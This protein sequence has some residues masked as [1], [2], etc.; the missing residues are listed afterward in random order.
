MDKS[1]FFSNVTK[2]NK[3]ENTIN[4]FSEYSSKK[5]KQVYII[6]SPLNSQS[7]DE[8][9][10]EDALVILIPGKKICLLNLNENAAKKFDEFSEDF[11][12]DL[13]YLSDKYDYKKILGRPRIWRN[14]LLVKMNISGCGDEYNSLFNDIELTSK[15]EQRNADFLISL[16]IGSINDINRVGYYPE[17]LLDQVKHKIILFDGDQS[18]FIYSNVPSK[19]KITIQG[20]AGTGKT[21]LLLHKLKDLYIRDK[22][23]KI[24]FTCFN[25]ILAES[26]RSRVPEFF[27]FM[28]VDEQIK[29]EERL[30]V[31]SSWGSS[32]VKNSGLYSYICSNYNLTF[33]PFSPKWSF[34]KVCAAALKELKGQDEI[35]P[36]FD[37]ILIDESQDFSQSFFEL[38]ELITNKTM[39]IAG[40]IF[41]DIYDRTLNQSVHSDFLLN[42]CY[43][44]DPKTLMFAHAVGMGLYETPV[45][46]WLDD[47]EWVSCGYQIDRSEGEFQLSRM[48]LRRFEDIETT[49]IPSI[50]VIEASDDYVKDVISII[51]EIREQNPSVK[52]CDI[53]VVFLESNNSNYKFA[54]LLQ[55]AINKKYKNWSAIKG[56][57]TKS[58]SEDAVFISNKNNIKGLEFPFVICVIN[59][60]LTRNVFK[61]NTVYMMLTRS[62]IT[63]YLLVDKIN[64]NFFEIYKD[65]PKTI[66]INGTMKLIEPTDEEKKLQN[67]KVQIEVN[68]SAKKRR[69][70]N[71]IISEIVDSYPQ[72]SSKN[73]SIIKKSILS[74]IEEQGQISEDE[75]K[76]RTKKFVD[77]FI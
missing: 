5:A 36:C 32:G 8:T 45:I 57:E 22:T 74:F 6:N 12:E 7:L 51:D 14:N 67:Q 43:R 19:K 48:P 39:Y 24:V 9:I 33:H 66:Q 59:E 2:N 61:R 60:E 30:W 55:L 44:T 17:T 38:C 65:I 56:Y 47:E 54:D 53:A 20:L 42:K 37:Y 62:F 63:S 18:R 76:I 28:R 49:N 23:S 3:N 75:I 15:K 40:D 71:D 58:T 52:A 73:K 41:Q 46:R 26:M 50:E 25:K 10:Y 13:G 69:P 21:E 16:L 72:L 68:E 4:F 1:L 31:M 34:E 70:I 29:W 27:D 77:A 64:H 35:T 11:L